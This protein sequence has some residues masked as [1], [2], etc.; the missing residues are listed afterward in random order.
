MVATGIVAAA[1][2]AAIAPQCLHGP[3]AQTDPAVWPIW[4]A[5]VAEMESLPAMAWKAPQSAM[6]AAAYPVLALLALLVVADKSTRGDFAFW[7]I[8]AAFLISLATTIGAIKG[9]PYAVWFGL[10]LVAVATT[11]MF[12][13]LGLNG[14]VPR[15]L[16]A[17]LVTPMVITGTAMGL[18][19]AMGLPGNAG[20]V[21]PARQACLS[22]SHIAAF[23]ALPPGLIVADEL[24]WGPYW[25]AWT[26][27]RVLAA[28]Y[29]R[30][31]D[32]IL[33]AERILTAPPEAARPMLSRIAADYLVACD[34]GGP[35]PDDSLRGRLQA[36]QLPDWAERLPLDPGPW[37]IYRLKPG[38]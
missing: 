10:P 1:V 13:R 28:P 38:S 34:T 6:A 32:S 23:A 20:V 27:H 30:I 14:L 31:S 3:Y 24:D 18:A 26:P 33:T 19:S 7:P 17:I 5:N 12:G 35:A 37:K 8:A 2:F 36:G 15:F 25:L 16:I 9:Y 11:R 29:H 21:T 4:L 22:R